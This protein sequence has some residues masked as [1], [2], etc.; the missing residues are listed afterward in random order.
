MYIIPKYYLYSSYIFEKISANTHNKFIMLITSCS[1]HS[2]KCV[3][4]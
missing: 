4:F 2:Y 3:S 1:V